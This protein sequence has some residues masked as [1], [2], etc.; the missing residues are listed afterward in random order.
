MKILKQNGDKLYLVSTPIGNKEDITYRA[1]EVLKKSDYI[2][3]EDTKNSSLFLS[4]FNIKVPL[5]SLHKF[6]ETQKAAEIIE[7]IKS[8]KVVSLISDA[9]TP[10]INDPGTFLA[11]E[12]VKN[13]IMLY[14]I[15]G[16]S[17]VSATLSINSY[18]SE[19]ITYLGFVDKRSKDKIKLLIEGN[20]DCIM[21]VSPHFIVNLIQKLDDDC[22]RNIIIA[23]EITKLHETHMY[24][25]TTEF[26]NNI[27]ELNLKGEFTMIVNKKD[28]S[29]KIDEVSIRIEQLIEQ[30]MSN[31]DIVKEI[32]STHNANKNEI[33]DLILKI[34]GN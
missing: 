24:L 33:Y 34:K 16:A 22:E 32:K 11:K 20:Q 4:H 26:L 21:L 15:V 10:L 25:T 18:N 6:N 12:L 5:R 17:A 27:D 28:K 14:P 1:L 9:G 23:K 13:E 3:C 30:N 8:G 19:I 29:I 31:K 2:Y 7:L